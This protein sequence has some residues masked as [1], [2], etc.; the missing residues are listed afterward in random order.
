M[1]T[2]QEL[3]SL[4]RTL[5]RWWPLLGLATALSA[6]TAWYLTGH[7]P[8]YYQARSTL[9]VGN[10]FSVSAP[11]Q[12]AVEV[13]NS[14][15]RYY[16]VL[17]RREVILQPAVDQLQLPIAWRSAAGMV[18]T[19]VN[20]RA[21]LLEIVIT[22]SSPERAAAIA[23]ALG[24]Q[25]IAYSPNAPEKVAAERAEIERQLAEAESSIST[26]DS[27]L[28]ELR[29]RQQ[30]LTAAVDLR[31]NEEQ[32]AELERVRDRV[33]E[34]YSQLLN[35]RNSSS[36]ST[37]SFF[38]R[39]SVPTRPL[40]QKTRLV[41]GGAGLGGLL[42]A[43]I[44]VFLL[45]LLDNRWRSGEDL[46][47][48]VGLRD[49]GRLVY[50]VRRPGAGDAQAWQRA[51]RETHTQLILA[52]AERP[53]RLLLV[54]SPGPSEPRSAYAIDLAGIYGQ[55][56]HRVLLVD[57]ELAQPR[58][59]AIVAEQKEHD[60][61]STQTAIERWSGRKHLSGHVP[62]E[63]LVRLRPTHL[64]NVA[65]LPSRQADDEQ[66]L[67][68]PL[69]HWP[70]LVDG[71]RNVAD[72]I[73]F[74]GP[75]SLT[76]ADAALLAPLVDG[77]VLVLDRD[78][79]SLDAVME[80]RAR[81]ERSQQARLLGA[82]T[83]VGSRPLPAPRYGRARRRRFSI[84]VDR[85]GVTITLPTKGA[86]PPLLEDGRERGQGA[87]EE[88]AEGRERA[89]GGQWAAGQAVEITLDELVER[90]RQGPEPAQPAPPGRV[91]I[92]PTTTDEERRSILVTPPP[93]QAGDELAR[94]GQAPRRKIT[95]GSS[96]RRRSRA[97]APPT[98]A[99][100]E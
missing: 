89:V 99:A 25:L 40:P 82:V 85:G 2:W 4:A 6:G 30:S 22:D 88:R 51:V 5:L 67:L 94:Q 98:G 21:N 14:L 39:A 9:M 49:L 57:A 34:N 8:D 86:G 83:V 55:A 43:A 60:H 26:M 79:D 17:V 48:R 31:D 69:L 28:D 78:E 42:V 59:T 18:E 52:S 16:E 24:E 20:P 63:L 32:I 58:L 47:R 3:W 36:T 93:E 75:S 64:A 29:Q 38:E 12:F 45:D 96:S 65:L 61:R 53:P 27:R 50:A 33:Q 11:N 54:S 84:S 95:R 23:N 68:V 100:E 73:I 91:I 76:S 10:N 37:L 71:L 56:G 35:L 44:A 97:G 62:Q 90:S 41:I 87:V 72:V 66:P 92:T 1:L 80:S 74:D 46:R 7:Q 81:L 19:E 13:S 77:V 15:A 70:E